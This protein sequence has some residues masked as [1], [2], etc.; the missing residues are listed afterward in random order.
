MPPPQSI[1]T[2]WK[3]QAMAYARRDFHRSPP[4]ILLSIHTPCKPAGTAWLTCL[5]T[6]MATRQGLPSPSSHMH[7]IRKYPVGVG[8]G[9]GW[10]VGIPLGKLFLPLTQTNIPWACLHCLWRSHK[11]EM[12]VKREQS[13]A[14]HSSLG[15]SNPQANSSFEQGHLIGNQSKTHIKTEKETTK[16]KGREESYGSPD[17]APLEGRQLGGEGEISIGATGPNQVRA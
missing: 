13:T 4:S 8:G 9:E 14:R 1:P 3:I 15:S 5:W 10:L 6:Y 12:R 16:G 17:T 7:L 11:G 2:I